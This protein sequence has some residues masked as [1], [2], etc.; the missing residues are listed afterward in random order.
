MISAYGEGAESSTCRDIHNSLTPGP[1]ETE[2]II[3]HI[4]QVTYCILGRAKNRAF[5]LLSI[6]QHNSQILLLS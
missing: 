4:A 2:D 3:L 6:Q 1:L 5:Y